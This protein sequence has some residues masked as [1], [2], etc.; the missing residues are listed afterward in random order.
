MKSGDA[1]VA[2][3]GFP[4]VGKVYVIMIKY[5]SCAHFHYFT[6]EEFSY[7]RILAEKN[8]LSFL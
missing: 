3:I 6:A 1:R 8:L 7:L 5:R 4:S 2:L